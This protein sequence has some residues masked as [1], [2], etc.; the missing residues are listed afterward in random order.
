[1]QLRIVFDKVFEFRPY[2]PADFGIREAFAQHLDGRQRQNDVTERAGFN[3]ENIFKN[4][5]H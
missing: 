2:E 4:L 3:D 1:M 5:F